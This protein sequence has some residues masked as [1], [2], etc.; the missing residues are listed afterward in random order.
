MKKSLKR[1]TAF[2]GVVEAVLGKENVQLASVSVQKAFKWVWLLLKQKR[3]CVEVASVGVFPPRT[4]LKWVWS[5]KI[6]GVVTLNALGSY[7]RGCGH[8][9][10][11]RMSLKGVWLLCVALVH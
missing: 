8:F 9:K 10:P 5:F 4:S 3:K 6:K 1:K 7:Y 2:V 11:T